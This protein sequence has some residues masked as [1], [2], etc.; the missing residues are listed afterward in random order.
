[1]VEST[2]DL[3]MNTEGITHYSMLFS[4]QRYQLNPLHNMNTPEGL[5]EFFPV[6]N[7]RLIVWWNSS[8]SAN[9]FKTQ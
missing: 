3:K 9:I 6:M 7:Y 1:M 4:M 2:L 8:N 5:L